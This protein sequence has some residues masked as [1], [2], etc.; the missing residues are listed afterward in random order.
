MLLLYN[1]G[2][3]RGLNKVPIGYG[4]EHICIVTVFILNELAGRI[5]AA[6]FRS[7]KRTTEHWCSYRRHMEFA[8]FSSFGIQSVNHCH[9]QIFWDSSLQNITF[10]SNSAEA[11]SLT[12]LPP[13]SSYQ[14]RSAPAYIYFW[15]A[16]K[17]KKSKIAVDSLR[18]NSTILKLLTHYWLGLKVP[19]CEIF[20]PFFLHQ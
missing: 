11:G 13:T 6:A 18:D 17:C 19:K 14:T 15:D 12:V 2:T 20:D 4:K 5:C 16:K 9:V 10:W 1:K 3:I 7:D 8:D